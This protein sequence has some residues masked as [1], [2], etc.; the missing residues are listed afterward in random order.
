MADKDK[1]YTDLF[2]STLVIFLPLITAIITANYQY[3]IT[4]WEE[5]DKSYRQVV[6]DLTSD[7]VDKRIAAAASLGTYVK[8]GDRH[9]SETIDILTNRLFMEDNR[10]VRNSIIGSLKKIKDE[11]E[12]RQVLDHLLTI[13]R[14]N[15]VQEYEFQR[16]ADGA[17]YKY[18]DA[19]EKYQQAKKDHAKN[20]DQS[21]QIILDNFR[22]QTEIK[23]RAYQTKLGAYDELKASNPAVTNMISVFLSEKHDQ[24]IIGLDFF[25]STMSDVLLTDL[26]LRDTKIKWTRFGL[27]VLTDSQ[28]TN[29][30]IERTYFDGSDLKNTNFA[31]SRI[32]NTV[33]SDALLI[34]TSFA[35]CKFKDVFF[36]GSDMQGANF[37]GAT[38]LYPE[39]FYDTRN[40]DLAIFADPSFIDKAQAVTAEQYRQFIAQSSLNDDKKDYLVP[41]ITS[42]QM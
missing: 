18:E 24:E 36:I 39:Y 34:N 35:N 28:L 42:A 38:G 8:I 1:P 10:N 26:V 22:Q 16:A 31:Q 11:P 9:L 4:R 15:F 40:L 37:I 14:T 21:D 23:R 7:T 32:S 41:G 20:S 5:S 27:S 19:L 29:S 30:T 17:K 25:R 2:K 12:Y 33:I 3:V 13:N 6:S